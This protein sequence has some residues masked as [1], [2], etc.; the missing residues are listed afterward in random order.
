MRFKRIYVEIGNICNL[1]CSF[2]S[3]GTRPK[4]Q[5]TAEEFK[6]I[7]KEI[8]PYTD[9]LYFHIKGEPLMHPE[10]GT[11]FDICSEYGFSVNLTTN[12]TLLKET[13]ELI[14]SKPSLRQINI[15]LHSF[16]AHK[17]IDRKEY[18]NTVLSFAK[19]ASLENKKYVVLRLWNLDKNRKS[20]KASFDIM[21]KIKT[22]F[23]FKE[24]LKELMTSQKSVMLEKGIFISWEEEFVWPSLKKPFVSDEGI[25]YGT[26]N[27]LGIL[28]DGTVV[29]CCLDANGEAPLG[30]IFKTSMK[31]IVEGETL[32]DISENFT[33]RRVTLP[34]CKH[35]SYRTRFDKLKN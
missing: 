17:S 22:F 31:S 21:E 32:A 2:C 28:A 24:N 5:M 11:F 25:C 26:R 14:L 34:L 12:G 15:S 1:N 27:M 18:L 3:K 30:N 29:P 9:Y 8:K 10:L 4:R 7:A 33:N 20:D 23:S 6:H 13:A 16:P 35:C 19:K